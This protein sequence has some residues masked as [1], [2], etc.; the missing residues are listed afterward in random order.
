[1]SLSKKQLKL[2]TSL[3][4]KKYRTNYGLFIAEGTK[5]VDEFLNSNFEL[6]QLFYVESKGYETYANATQISEIELK[7]IS[8][9]KTPNNVLAI[10][11]IP[12]EEKIL[13][14]GFILALDEINDPGNLGTI[15][16]LC[17][18]FG[19]DQLVCSKNTTDC[20]N[21]KV[22]Q[23]SMGSLTRVSIVYTDLLSYLKSTELPKFATLMDGENVYKIKL[24]KQAI[25]VMG[26]EANGISEN[27]LKV[28]DNAIS[29]PRFGAI[30]QTESLN[31]ATAT[32]ILLSEFKRLT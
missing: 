14:E 11:K 17:D 12:T 21:A 16:R 19:V 13:K 27:I 29:I 24:P 31:V 2:I 3:Q 1:M 30:Q 6:D 22:V 7:K 20:Y 5:V 25:L 4:Q 18:W 9:L 28:L 15:I 23:A 10:F 8:L 26:N 32:A